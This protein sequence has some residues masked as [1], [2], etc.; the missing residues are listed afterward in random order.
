MCLNLF[1]I[2]NNIINYIQLNKLCSMWL[3]KILNNDCVRIGYAH[4]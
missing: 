2:D 1:N 3:L 4:V